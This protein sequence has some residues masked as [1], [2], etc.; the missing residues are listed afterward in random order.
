MTRTATSVPIWRL[1]SRADTA[2]GMRSVL[3]GAGGH[4]AFLR[5]IRL[6]EMPI[7]TAMLLL[8]L[9]LVP[10]LNYHL[11]CIAPV[12]I[13]DEARLFDQ[14]MMEAAMDK[15]GLDEDERHDR[16]TTLLQRRLRDG[17]WGLASAA[18]TS[19]AGFLGSMAACR[20]EPVFA[21]YCG[22]S[23]SPSASQLHGWLDDSI[24]RVRQ[25]APGKSTRPTSNR[26]CQLL[27]ALSSAST[28]PSTRPSPLSFSAHS[29][30]RPLN[31]LL[32]P[33]MC[34]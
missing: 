30:R 31:T 22:D 34:T 9:C 29:T 23:P 33:P 6:D 16:T 11:R 20:A 13:E 7:Q 17:G 26:C 12:C 27:L 21:Q 2:E 24:L 28:P 15:L 5:R 4:D 19:P 10:S 3:A 8:R 32:R 25:A 18:S 1:S 14:R